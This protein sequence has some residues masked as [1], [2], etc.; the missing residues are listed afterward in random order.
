M[1]YSFLR[2]IK[3]AF[4]D[5]WRNF[6]LSVVT[7]TVLVLA[8]LSVNVLISLSAV[9]E[10]IV[11]SIQNHVDISVFF[12]G[13]AEQAQV[14]NFN[15]RLKN[16]PEIK[17]TEF[18]S[19]D[20][21]LVAFK[22]KHK[23]D[24][25][26]LEALQELESNPLSGSVVIKAKNVEDYGK[27]L[28]FLQLE[29][30]KSII[31]YQNYTDYKKIIEQVQ[32]ISGKVEKFSLALTIFFAIIAILIVFNSIKVT[33]YT[34]KEEISV[35]RLV[36]ATSGFIRSPFLLEAIL[37]AII[38]CAISIGLL[39]LILGALGPYLSNFLEAYN[40]N[41]V[42]YYNQNF[43]VIFG[44]ELLAITLL[45]IFSSGIAIGRYLKV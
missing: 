15:V 9:S 35:M 16:L 26:I 3:Y 41:L 25:M 1:N 42:Q 5:F 29:E 4:Q 13:E 11:G 43:I 22:A 39:Y 14:D 7:L 40:F 21:A 30:N 27:I 23:D 20:S 17:S 24:P 32:V 45:N 12:K 34:H 28:N 2:A 37:F 19:S 36:G 8:L 10:K 33:I 6:W 18:V 44:L 38:A 31:K